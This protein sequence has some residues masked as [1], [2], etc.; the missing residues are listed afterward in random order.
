[1]LR[2]VVLTR[3]VL[4]HISGVLHFLYIIIRGKNLIKQKDRRRTAVVHV[5]TTLRI[6]VPGMSDLNY[7]N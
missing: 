3:L 2:V 1:M 5:T 7:K 6:L 4:L